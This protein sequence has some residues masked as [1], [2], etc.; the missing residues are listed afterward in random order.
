MNNPVTGPHPV[1]RIINGERT[2]YPAMAYNPSNVIYI[3]FAVFDQRLRLRLNVQ[4][5]DTIC[6][7]R[8]TDGPSL[9]RLTLEGPSDQHP[10]DAFPRVR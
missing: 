2:V 6:V 1:H 8:S 5:Q 4:Y 3:E 9:T 7:Y 10:L